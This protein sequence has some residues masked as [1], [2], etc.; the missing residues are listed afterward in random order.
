M[1]FLQN[2]FGNITDHDSG[3]KYMVLHRFGIILTVIF[4]AGS[5]FASDFDHSLFDELLKNNVRNGLVDYENI[6]EKDLELLQDYLEEMKTIDPD[7]FETW[8]RNAK[9]ALWINAYNAVTMYAIVENYPIQ[10]G[11]LM[12]RVRF[13][14]NSI[15]Q[16]K[17]VWD[18][19]HVR[20]MGKELTLNEIEHTILRKEFKD[21]RIHF[22]IVCASIGCPKLLNAAYLPEKLEEQLE[23][24]TKEFILDNNYVLLDM[25]K[26]EIKLSS[27]F[28][29]YKEDFPVDHSNNLIRK[30][31]KNERGFIW[32]VF[33][34]LVESPAEHDAV[35][36]DKMRIKYSDYDWSL[37]EWRRHSRPD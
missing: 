7:D 27:I 33:R 26:K 11:G 29:W 21:P 9:M 20:I 16:I 31:G 23:A 24:A 25:Q 32:F 12:S 18:T 30:Y 28:D 10:Y 19:V 15:R 5:L 34:Y 36:A 14:K 37:N 13:P 8:D 17:N 2:F 6:K 22:A 3:L 4:A 35:M 1:G